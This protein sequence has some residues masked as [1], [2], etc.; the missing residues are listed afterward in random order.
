MGAEGPVPS[1]HQEIAAARRDP[2]L[3]LGREAVVRDWWEAMN[4][5]ERTRRYYELGLLSIVR[6]DHPKDG[7]STSAADMS[8]AARARR[9]IAQAELDNELA[10]MGA[11]VL[12][13]MVSA[14]DAMVEEMVPQAR[15]ALTEMQAHEMHDRVR[16]DMP[17]LATTVTD[18]QL[19]E[20]L[21]A[22]ISG[23]LDTRFPK[24]RLRPRLSGASRWESLLSYVGLQAPLSRPIPEVLDE[25]LAEV[26]QLRHAIAHRASRVDAEALRYA[27]TL[28]YEENQLVRISREDY[29]R[30]S[31]ALRT[32]GDEVT[33]R[34]L[35]PS[36]VPDLPLD[37]WRRNRAINS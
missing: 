25:A 1:E 13:A 9:D 12:V 2:R 37:Q 8:A 26:V 31:A 11:M 17:A 15:K 24:R 14:L 23:A 28:K 6:H 32:Y 19:L 21:K 10:E 33:R 20:I 34:M 22:A 29:R 16:R 35:G 4:A 18:E 7:D 5:A 30:Y 3:S 36:V 27:P